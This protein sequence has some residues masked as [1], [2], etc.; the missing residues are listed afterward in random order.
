MS[1]KIKNLLDNICFMWYNTDTKIKEIAIS[2][3]VF[4]G[5]RNNDTEG[6]YWEVQSN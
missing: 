4:A 1:E 2:K 5:G 6:I 3:Y